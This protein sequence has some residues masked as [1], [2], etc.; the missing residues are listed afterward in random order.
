VLLLAL[1]N[2]NEMIKWGTDL[3]FFFVVGV[4]A[5]E[6][7]GVPRGGAGKIDLL[8]MLGLLVGGDV[9]V[10]RRGFSFLKNSPEQP[11]GHDDDEL[12]RGLGFGQ[13]GERF[14]FD[15]E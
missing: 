2:S 8:L 11:G 6:I 7:E 15:R 3:V 1:Q 10:L 13:R 12:E 5:E 4:V 9:G 14:F